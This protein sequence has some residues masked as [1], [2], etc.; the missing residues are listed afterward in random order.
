MKRVDKNSHVFP[1]PSACLRQNNSKGEGEEMEEAESNLLLPQL[2]AEYVFFFFPFYPSCQ[3]LRGTNSDMKAA[4]RHSA[5]APIQ[6]D[7][8]VHTEKGPP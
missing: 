7:W 1:L 2:V 3:Q 6:S 5:L 4:R 8:D